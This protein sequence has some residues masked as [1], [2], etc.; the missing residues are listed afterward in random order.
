[1]A[2]AVA[3]TAT[4]TAR[5]A[6]VRSGWALTAFASAFLLF[7]S[8]IHILRIDPVV[9]GAAEF[10]LTS[11]AMLVIGLVELAC[12]AVYLIPR[13]NVI[14]A[15]LLTGYLGG[16]VCAQAIAGAPVGSTLL[17]PVY[18]GVVVWAGLWLRDPAVRA[19][20]PVRR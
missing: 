13:T 12:L 16:A 5:S 1:M 11:R 7:D 14:G 10:G 2:T 8:V 18:V 15:V 17:F 20:V 4:R 9:K 6:A 19:M 3:T